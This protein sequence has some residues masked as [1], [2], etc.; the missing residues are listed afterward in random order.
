M[1][2]RL[3]HPQAVLANGIKVVNFCFRKCLVFED[4][5]VLEPCADAVARLC[6]PQ[7]QEVRL[8]HSSGRW[9]EYVYTHHVSDTITSELDALEEDDGV[10][11]ILVPTTL[12]SA[13]AI[14]G[15]ERYSKVRSPKYKEPGAPQ[16][17]SDRF[18]GPQW[19][20][21]T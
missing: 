6:S 17:Y 4:G 11:I 7:T 8:S 10:D 9:L 19:L 21:N 18:L 13:L 14:A 2:E 12:M 5:T 3:S 1:S 20:Y 15:G 16:V